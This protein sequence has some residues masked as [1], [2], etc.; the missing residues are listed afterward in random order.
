[1]ITPQFYNSYL[2]NL[3]AGNRSGCNE[4]V[5]YLLD[6]NIDIKIL[7][8]KL[9]QQSLYDV[10][11][12]WEENRISVA[13]EH[14]ATAITE[15]L[16]NLIYPRLFITPK[17]NNKV[18]ISCTA[19]E[20]HQ[21]GGKIIAD[22]F[23]LHGWNSHFVGANTPVEHLISYIDE[24]TPDVVGLSLSIYF[25]LPNL[26][27]TIEKIR[28]NFSKLDLLV[29]GQAF[30]WGITEALNNFSQTSYIPSLDVLENFILG[31]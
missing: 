6:Q 18:I 29:G 15:S 9:I 10:G 27:S 3:L 17:K 8:V 13:K 22:F 25:N 5:L 19:N 31:E 2:E 14:L 20:Y 1:M 16:L 7:Y 28:S 23:E 21:V 4:S 24:I 12:L 26:T 30:Q 11:K